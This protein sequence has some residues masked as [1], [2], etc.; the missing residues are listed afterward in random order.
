MNI[1]SMTIQKLLFIFAGLSSVAG[2]GTVYW[3]IFSGPSKRNSAR[4]DQV[5]TRLIDHD[6]RMCVIEQAQKTLPTKDD[7]HQVNLAVAALQSEIATLRSYLEGAGM[8]RA[9]PTTRTTNKTPS[10]G[11]D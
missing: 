1:A 5:E 4:L 2:F 11:Q 7:L 8:F 9:R 6:L 3:N 10:S